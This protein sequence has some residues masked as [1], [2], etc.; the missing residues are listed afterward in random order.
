MAGFGLLLI[1]VGAVGLIFGLRMML[2]AKKM[3]TV[4]FHTPSEIA[5]S[6]A[7]LADP[8]GL[9]STEGE[10]EFGEEVLV[11]PMSGERCLAYT[12]QLI[13]EF[14]KTEQTSEGPKTR[15][16][17][18]QAHGEYKGAK[19]NIKDAQGG[20]VVIDPDKSPDADFV[21]THESKVKIGMMIPGTLAFG[22]LEMQTPQL[23]RDSRTTAFTAVEKIVKPGHMYALGA[24]KDGVVTTPKGLTG[25]LTLSG[26]GREKLLG[27]TLR[28][29]KL[30]YGI[31]AGALVV[32]IVLSVIA[33]K[34][35]KAAAPAPTSTATAAAPAPA[36]AD[37]DAANDK[38]LDDLDKAL[39]N[40]SEICQKAAA[41][42]TA[43]AGDKATDAQLKSCLNFAKLPAAS[44][45]SSVKS[46][47][48]AAKASKNKDAI[49]LCH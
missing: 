24:Y 38:A 42:C 9:I 11:A 30:G 14:E 17:V 3:R 44:C 39:D 6:G 13:R 8:K 35:A 20:I 2:K 16:G 18:E 29:M 47:Y 4:P 33:P 34:P 19:F 26:K 40:A 21:K 45:K 22:K 25:T 5:A 48:K 36:A 10:A 7:S 41:C 1:V 49:E 28:N 32:G 37:D 43:L 46:F 15:S 23:P 31:G 12:I 27:T